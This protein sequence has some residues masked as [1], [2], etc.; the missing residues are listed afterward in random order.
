[1]FEKVRSGRVWPA[2][3][4]GVLIGLVEVVLA[5]AFATLVSNGY[6]YLFQKEA[7]GLY[8]AGAAIALAGLAWSAGHRGARARVAL[9][10]PNR[11]RADHPRSSFVHCA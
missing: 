2:L 6:L 11:A 8:L 4:V 3:G 10:E 7:I 9:A 5:V 1:M